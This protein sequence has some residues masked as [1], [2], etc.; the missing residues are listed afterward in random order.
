MQIFTRKGEGAY[1]PSLSVGVGSHGTRSL[2]VGLSGTQGM[3]DYAL[4]LGR[5]TSTGFNAQPATNPDKD[6]HRRT[7]GSARLGLQVNR[8][9]RL[10]ATWLGSDLSLI[11]I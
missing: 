10:E 1:S 5:E 8:E 4:G 7:T 9:H 11:H 2:N 6:G 3:W